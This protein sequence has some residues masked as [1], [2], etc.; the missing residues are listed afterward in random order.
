V[1]EDVDLEFDGWTWSSFLYFHLFSSLGLS[2]RWTSQGWL[3]V[4]SQVCVPI[5]KHMRASTTYFST[6]G[7]RFRLP[8]LPYP[9]DLPHIIQSWREK[10]YHGAGG[11]AC[12]GCGALCPMRGSASVV[13][14]T[15]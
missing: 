7:K 15:V 9:R 12:A 5:A 6:L 8:Q 10:P 2:L 11:S 1:T 4:H 3:Y 13:I 14:R